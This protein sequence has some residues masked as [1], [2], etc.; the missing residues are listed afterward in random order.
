M[1][2]V[3]VFMALLVVSPAAQAQR[4]LD[5]QGAKDLFNRATTHFNLGK[6]KEAAAEYEQLYEARPVPS[7]LYNIAQ[8]H[9]LDGNAERALF[10]YKSYL[11]NSSTASN[12]EEVLGRIATLEKLVEQQRRPPNETAPL[13]GQPEVTAPARP[14]EPAAVVIAAPVAPAPAKTPI[15]RKWW[16]WTAVGAAVVVG[17]G[18]GV[19]VSQSGTS[20]P[21]ASPTSGGT[22]QF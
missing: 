22:F 7:L 5:K 11:R 10:F 16:L 1:R 15:Y 8:A 19:G 4:E 14:V 12:R 21:A 2:T 13:G 9:R 18:V 20:Y 6:F 17:V 3:I